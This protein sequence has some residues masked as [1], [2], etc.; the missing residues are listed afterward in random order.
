[1]ALI[2]MFVVLMLWGFAIG[3]EAK[4]DGKMRWVIGSII[5]LA[6]IV[7]VFWSMGYNWAILDLVFR[8]DWSKSFWTNTLF[9]AIA[10]AAIAWAMSGGGSGGDD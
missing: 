2:V 9:I 5:V 1:V 3:G 7:A 10:A 4:V 6:V 8:Q